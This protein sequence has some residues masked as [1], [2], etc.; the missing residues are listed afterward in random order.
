MVPLQIG[1]FVV[2]AMETFRDDLAEGAPAPASKFSPI[3]IP[4][5]SSNRDVL[6]EVVEFVVGVDQDDRRAISE[7]VIEDEGR[8]RDERGRWRSP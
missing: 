8:N 3:L 5:S 6:D 7:V 2:K 4:E 1:Q